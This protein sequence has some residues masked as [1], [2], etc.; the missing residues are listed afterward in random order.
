[1]SR[2]ERSPMHW[3]SFPDVPIYLDTSNSHTSTKTYGTTPTTP[4]TPESLPRNRPTHLSPAHINAPPIS[5]VQQSPTTTIETTSDHHSEIWPIPEPP[6][7][8]MRQKPRRP[9]LQFIPNTRPR[10][11]LGESHLKPPQ[12]V[13]DVER[14]DFQDRK[15]HLGLGISGGP[16]K[17][18]SIRIQPPTF[19]DEKG[20]QASNIA[21]RIEE[22][23]WNYNSSGNVIERW[24]LEIVS[25]LISA[26]CM[27]AIIAVLI[28]LK[29]K[30]STRWPFDS[31]GLTLNAF[32]SVLSRIAGAALLLPVAEAIGQL[33]W[34]WFIKGDSKKMW[35]FEMF[36]NASRGPWGAFLLLIHT[37][38]KTIAALGAL[39][40]I[41]ALA[42]DPF[43]QQV[44]SF[45]ERWTLQHTNSS[46]SRVI[47][48]EPVYDIGYEN[49]V[50]MADLNGEI[51]N[52]AE[53]FFVNNGTQPI[54]FG[55][56]TRAEIPLS[57]PSSNCTWPSYDTLGMCSQ[58]VEV[59]NLLNFTCMETRVDWTSQLTGNQST[60][61]T[62]KVC[63]YFL[64]ATSEQPILMSGYMLD[65]Q[66]NKAGE[67]LMM[68]TVPLTSYPLRDPLW[69]DGSINF[70][71]VR[72]P[73]V[74]ALISSTASS[75]DV[76]AD[77]IPI[78]HE[79]VLSWCVKTIQSSYYLGTYK[80]E[81]TNTFI[82]DTKGE[83]PWAT[84]ELPEEGIIITDYLENVTIAAPPTDQGF[85][86]Y[87]WGVNNDT[88]FNVVLV[89][90]RIFPS[91][92]TSTNYSET[93]VFR[94]RTG[95]PTI[96]Y[97][98][99]PKFNPWLVPNDIP[100]HLERMTSSLTNVI[101]SSSSGE[102]V[103]GKAFDTEVYVKVTWAWLSLPLCLLFV[104]CVFLVS[105]VIKSATEKGQVSI[106]KNSAI[107]TLLYG[108]PDH[109]Q[110][111]LAKSDSKG[112][113]RTQAKELKVRLSA[114]RGWRSSGNAFTPLTPKAP[115]NV[116]PPGWI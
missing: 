84:N 29:D 24:L 78:L 23:L 39:V 38:G 1:M 111:R 44:V 55:N 40:T 16:P 43:F 42:L 28:V 45:P 102:S 68:R 91:F 36:D 94:W 90:D 100:R 10:I 26:I 13:P 106:R 22:K 85:P 77:K 108:L 112:T 86:E 116:P 103:Y 57:C 61:P 53:L 5:P 4:T 60:Y 3:P 56:G 101:R 33:K 95:N 66:G 20:E 52:V 73:I 19:N 69:G 81:V 107:A 2:S 93:P 62:A 30:P 34:S 31:M 21:Q 75:A 41:F 6:P 63:G 47:R 82:N 105:T 74:D 65:E 104:S 67:A 89:F 58:C 49:G 32:V 83:Y 87:G 46:I 71:E 14:P 11:Q 98:K 51:Q 59:S 70:K 54:P 88:M 109:F 15:S 18:P 12:Q 97:A 8:V 80:E 37:K 114:T 9:Q 48:Y 79:C 27:A 99:I 17:P 35:D 76:F 72:N 64:N 50:D 92:T 25:W 96:A 115:T 110:K 113:P 7:E